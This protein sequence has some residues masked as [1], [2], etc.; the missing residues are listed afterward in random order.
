MGELASVI[1]AKSQTTVGKKCFEGYRAAL[2]VDFATLASTSFHMLR[3]LLALVGRGGLAGGDAAAPAGAT[4]A[5]ALS[6]CA[7]PSGSPK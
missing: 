3:Y 2:A 7:L 5:A 6:V 4:R 1:Q